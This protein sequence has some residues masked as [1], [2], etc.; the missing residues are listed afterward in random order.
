MAL[1]SEDLRREVQQALAGI[2]AGVSISVEKD[3]AGPPLGYPINIEIV[4]DDYGELIEVGER[5]RNF[6][7]DMNIPGL[8]NS[9][10]MSIATNP[11]CAS[12]LI[13]K[14]QENWVLVLDK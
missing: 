8:R 2:F 11:V 7:I 14:K 9:K 10:S 5:M 12:L 13:V 6:I 4:G 1:S 3:Q